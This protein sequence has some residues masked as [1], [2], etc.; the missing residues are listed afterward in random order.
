MVLGIILCVEVTSLGAKKSIEGHWLTEDG[1]RVVK[2]MIDLNHKLTGIG[3]K[4]DH[5]K[6]VYDV[7]NPDPKLK[8][9]KSRWCYH[10][11]GISEER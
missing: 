11:M 5:Q 2:I 10:P 3:V 1:D 8:R 9:E 4:Q 7:H 6:P